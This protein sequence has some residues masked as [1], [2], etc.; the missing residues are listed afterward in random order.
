M[1]VPTGPMNFFIGWPA[2]ATGP[3]AELAPWMGQRLDVVA[4]AAQP[5]QCLG[6]TTPVMPTIAAHL[7]P[8]N[9]PTPLWKAVGGAWDASDGAPVDLV[10]IADQNKRV[11]GFGFPGF[12]SISGS[13]AP[14]DAGWASFFH[15]DPGASIRAYGILDG[16]RRICPI[17]GTR[18]LPPLEVGQ[19]LA[20]GPF[21]GGIE[22]VPG[23]E[24]VQRFSPKALLSGV[25]LQVQFLTWARVPSDYP[26]H[27]RVVQTRDGLSSQIGSGVLDAGGVLDGEVAGL[28]V[29]ATTGAVPD[30][31]AVIFS[32]EGPMPASPIGVAT[33]LPL[34]GETVP[35]I[36]VGGRVSQTEG[37]LGLKLYWHP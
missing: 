20:S 33:F 35:P 28:Q 15:A 7:Q 4:T 9:D 18:Y 1:V 11:V 32:A 31:I 6:Q 30:E 12:A 23:R 29:D 16:G 27:W 24:V 19:S 2:T 17:S 36:E 22:I 10:V 14:P 37:R 34:P 25:P 3:L 26:V 8:R 5:A 13:T 21:A